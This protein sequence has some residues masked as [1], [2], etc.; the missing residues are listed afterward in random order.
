MTVQGL[1]CVTLVLYMHVEFNEMLSVVETHESI[2]RT[3]ELRMKNQDGSRFSHNCSLFP[4]ARY[5]QP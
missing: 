3:T 2:V 5:D 1:G 4:F